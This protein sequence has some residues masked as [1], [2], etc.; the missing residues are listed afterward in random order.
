LEA[1]Q[2]QGRATS[3]RLDR[4]QLGL[5]GALLVLALLAWFVTDNRMGE[6]DSTPGMALGSL[7]FFVTVWVVMMAAMMFPSVA[8]TV[9]MYDRLR[10]GHRARGRGAAP[11][12]TALFVAG[13]LLVWTLAGL[14]AYAVFELVRVIDPPFLAWD[15]AGRYVT[16]G[17]IVAAAIYQVTPLKHAC[18]VK[19]RS[20][21]MFLAER[22]R[23]GRGGGLELG[24]RHGA[25]CLGCCWALMAA[26]FAVGVMSLGWMALI[27]AFIAAEKLLPWPV[28]ARRTV[29]VLLLFLGL[30]IAIAPADVPGFAEPGMSMPDSGGGHG[31]GM[32][33]MR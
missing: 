22:W 27:A 19:C 8:P 3:S 7:G 29:T 30:G 33:M 26:L 24:A 1:A 6:M 4:A 5:L 13:Y 16:A 17:V 10:E 9:L 18:L 14:G 21:M 31:D 11:D 12:A 2:V 15:E 25:W 28:V 23:H 32:Q 20:P